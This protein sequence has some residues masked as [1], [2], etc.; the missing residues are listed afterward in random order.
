M[1]NVVSRGP[2]VRNLS[3]GKRLFLGFGA[4]LVLA[5]LIAVVGF[6]RLQATSVATRAL[7]DEPLAKER[8][9]SDWYRLIHTSVRRTTAIAKSNDSTLASFFAEETAASS[10]TLSENQK[11]IE[12]LLRS[13]E[14]R[15][16][17]AGVV[18]ARKEYIRA[19]D[20]V[21]AL[22]LK[23]SVEEASKVFDAE[24]VPASK[25][26]LAQLQ[27]MLLHQRRVIDDSAA[28]INQTN[29]ASR[30]LLLALSG[31]ALLAGAGFGLLIARS[32]TGPIHHAVDTARRVASGDLSGTVHVDSRDETGLLLQALS[33]MQK[34]LG[35]V[36]GSVRHNAESL[37][38]ASAQIASGNNDL[39]ARTEQQA[40]A[41]EQTVA[42]M[43]QLSATV[44]DNA[45]N[46]RRANQMATGAT[47]AAVRGGE[48]VGQVV[49]T[50]KG[51]DDSSKKIVDIIG[52]IEGIAFQTNILA[53]NAAVEAANAGEQ[54]RGFAVVASEVR[55]LAERSGRA[56]K[57]IKGLIT[58]SVN[59]VREGSELVD[60]AG[61]TMTEIV[62]EIQR[63]GDVVAQI[64][65]ASAEQSSGVS[66][67]GQ[68]VSQMDQATQQNAALVEEGA[69]AAESLKLLATEL[70]D[71]TAM[72]KT[73]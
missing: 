34:H 16:L 72:F 1:R 18:V 11:A 37:A 36:L 40:S 23:G 39:S 54:G 64:S 27:D 61:H 52:V 49:R 59:E 41:L 71:A 44:R 28:R 50:M 66:Q 63:L 35:G 10:R 42:T 62:A 58:Q 33:D 56:A 53:L 68:A 21:S 55:S 43:Q 57:E 32:I 5:M 7:L 2:F 46:A 22:Q 51:I 17:L 19:R 38:T 20:A 48:V 73:A 47:D 13:D 67:I 45:D 25:S 14:E 15:A 60:Q 8:L 31:L 24:F 69:A 4:V 12:G 30:L 65:S 6:W 26:Y 29:D 70:A 9:I 3:I